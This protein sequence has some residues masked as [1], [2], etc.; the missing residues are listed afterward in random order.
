MSKGG[1]TKFVIQKGNIFETLNA[2]EIKSFLRSKLPVSNK[3]ASTKILKSLKR[4]EVVNSLPDEDHPSKKGSKLSRFAGQKPRDSLRKASVA[5]SDSFS[6]AKHLIHLN[7]SGI[8]PNNSGEAS[9]KSLAKE[10]K[11]LSNVLNDLNDSIQ[12]SVNSN[13]CSEY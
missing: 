3:D 9:Q 13:M 1:V 2:P 5:N 7:Q 4:V 11:L 10:N 6:N 8:D 12:Y